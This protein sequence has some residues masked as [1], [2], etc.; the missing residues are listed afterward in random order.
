MCLAGKVKSYT[1]WLPF[2]HAS[3]GYSGHF[4]FR[5]FKHGTRV[6][7]EFLS[8][9]C[10]SVLASQ[11]GDPIVCIY[12][13]CTHGPR[14]FDFQSILCPGMRRWPGLPV[15]LT[16]RALVAC[17]RAGHGGSCGKIALK[18]R[19]KPISSLFFCPLRLLWGKFP[20]VVLQL[21]IIIIMIMAY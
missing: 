5:R 11:G 13:K 8:N 15:M 4:A 14:E 6:S 19:P 18:P 1:M 12:T 20:I 21:D 16:T 9:L 3:T 10:V 17:G 2:L 7:A